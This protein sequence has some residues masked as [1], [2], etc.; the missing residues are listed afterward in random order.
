LAGLAL[1]RA[2]LSTTSLNEACR[3]AIS[4]VGSGFWI[5]FVLVPSPP[6]QRLVEHVAKAALLEGP[7]R[8]KSRGQRLG[9]FLPQPRL[10]PALGCRL[11]AGLASRSI[12]RTVLP[13]HRDPW[14][15]PPIAIRASCARPPRCCCCHHERLGLA[16]GRGMGDW[17]WQPAPSCSTGSS[18]AWR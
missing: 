2:S 16:S 14:F 11:R 9:C 3:T 1:Q 7:K 13:D 5:S 6:A 15:L 4:G 8:R 17:P 10:G 18:G 12:R